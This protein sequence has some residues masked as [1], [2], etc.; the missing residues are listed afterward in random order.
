[1][2]HVSGD[3]N[4]MSYGTRSKSLHDSVKHKANLRGSTFPRVRTGNG[5]SNKGTRSHNSTT[6]DSV[7]YTTQHRTGYALTQ[8]STPK[9]MG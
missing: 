2:R 8:P 3:L 6:Q 4:L 1:M 5:N 7:R 9:K